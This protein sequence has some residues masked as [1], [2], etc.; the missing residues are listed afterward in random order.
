[1]SKIANKYVE[2]HD[3]TDAILQSG[4]LFSI[5]KTKIPYY[6][7]IL[8]NTYK[9]SDSKFLTLNCEELENNLYN[10][11]NHI[12]VMSNSVK[13]SL[14]QDYGINE[15]FISVVGVGPNISPEK[16]GIKIE[17]IIYKRTPKSILFV[18]KGFEMG[19]G[20]T[21]LEAFKK[22]RKEFPDSSLNIVSD[23]IGKPEPNVR[24]H[25]PIKYD[26]LITLFSNCSLFIIPSHYE[27]F[28]IA[29]IEAMAFALPCI[30][31][32]IGAIPE[33]ILDNETGFIVP[34]MDSMA[35]SDKIISIIS[36][37]DE[38]R[39]MGLKGREI[40]LNNFTW[41]KVIERMNNVIHRNLVN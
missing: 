6:L 39:E 40:Y 3:N 8:D 24:W 14:V 18:K 37:E 7:G 13:T 33:L 5:S 10:K 35:I 15:I 22:I 26:Q 30:G 23:Y 28:G 38:L 1:M 21:L 31:T 25:G 9:M 29:L 4:G 34:P 16:Y 36:N 11:A 20:Y 41:N 32:N 19:G 2:L 17:N 27:P 12:F